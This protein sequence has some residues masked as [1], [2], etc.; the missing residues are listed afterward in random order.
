MNSN[1]KATTNK[2]VMKKGKESMKSRPSTSTGAG[3]TSSLK[4]VGNYLIDLERTLG[5]GQSGKVYLASEVMA[6]PST[7]ADG[8]ITDS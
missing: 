7:G 4:K 8:A 3:R 5:E 2:A 1:A 6:V